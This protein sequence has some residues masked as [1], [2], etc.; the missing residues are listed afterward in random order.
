MLH[1]RK[2]VA[3]AFQ[4]AVIALAAPAITQP[5]QGLVQPAFN[6]SSAKSVSE[7]IDPRFN[8][9]DYYNKVPLD[10][11]SCLM[12]AVNEMAN[13]ALLPW[14]SRTRGYRSATLPRYPHVYM[15]ITPQAPAVD[16]ETRF[17]I[18]GINIAMYNIIHEELFLESSF[19]LSFSTRAVGWI[20]F[21]HQK[22]SILTLPPHQDLPEVSNLT[23][24]LGADQFAAYIAKLLKAK[25]LDKLSVFITIYDA[26]KA[27][28]PLPSTAIFSATSLEVKPLGLDVKA[29]FSSTDDPRLPREVPPFLEWQWI[30]ETLRRIPE[31]MLERK[32]FQ[33]VGVDITVDGFVVGVAKVESRL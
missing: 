4:I 23:T 31:W 24:A 2:I 10:R 12:V 13:L 3:V 28:A 16:I 22:P 18:W 33:E 14:N 1:L 32:A 27:V 8:V 7:S 6:A 17:L 29:T 20:R 26:F 15:E 25:E 21:R 9:D 11:D 19:E 5:P 30:V